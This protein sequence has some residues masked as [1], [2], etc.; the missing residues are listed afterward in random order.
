[1]TE[2]EVFASVQSLRALVQDKYSFALGTY[3]FEW[4]AAPGQANGAVIKLNLLLQNVVGGTSKRQRLEVLEVLSTALGWNPGTTT[5][6]LWQTYQQL[7]ARFGRGGAERAY[8]EIRLD[9][10]RAWVFGSTKELWNAEIYALIE[11]LEQHNGIQTLQVI[12]RDP[13][14]WAERLRALPP[15]QRPMEYAPPADTSDELPIFG[16]HFEDLEPTDFEISVGCTA[17]ELYGP[18]FDEELPF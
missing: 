1:M 10:A 16:T 6:A 9:A 7:K 17:E 13:R 18:A 12:A 3:H 15:V 14:A 11:W 8:Q 2:N 5:E 4:L